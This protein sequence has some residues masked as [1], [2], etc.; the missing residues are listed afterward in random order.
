[1]RKFAL[2]CSVLCLSATMFAQS[3]PQPQRLVSEVNVATPKP[4][5]AAQFEAGRKAHSAF[6]AAQKDTWSVLVWEITTGERTGAY[7]MASPGHH[8]AEFDARADFMKLDEA[9]VAK[10]L[11][12]YASTTTSDYAFRDDLSLSKPPAT[13]SAMR[14]AVY[15]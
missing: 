6:H 15:Y 7:L 12:P 8:W 10:N 11:A 9:D 1:M 13:P 2:S 14:T 4:G 3:T 5:M